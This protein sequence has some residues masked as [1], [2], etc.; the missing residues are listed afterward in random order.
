[1]NKK[2]NFS[3]CKIS[4]RCACMI[5]TWKGEPESQFSDY[6][7]ALYVRS[8]LRAILD[9][10][11]YFDINF[12]L[13]F[14]YKLCYGSR[15]TR[16]Y[17]WCSYIN[18]VCTEGAIFLNILKWITAKL[19]RCFQ[20]KMPVHVKTITLTMLVVLTKNFYDFPAYSNTIVSTHPLSP[21]HMK[22]FVQFLIFNLIVAKLI[23]AHMSWKLKWA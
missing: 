10:S 23:L 7:L 2:K 15:L 19:K 16:H 9:S 17:F 3:L 1:M 13:Y 11:L 6:Y 21:A 22:V 20:F 12:P 18:F 5:R 4:E 14:V 8:Q